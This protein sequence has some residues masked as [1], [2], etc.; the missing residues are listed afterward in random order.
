MSKTLASRPALDK[1][2]LA[3]CASYAGS[4]GIKKKYVKSFAS[5]P[6]LDEQSFARCES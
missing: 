4:Y 1:Q 2:S 6:A 3:H 5:R